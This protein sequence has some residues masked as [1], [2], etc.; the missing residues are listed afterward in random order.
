[1]NRVRTKKYLLLSFFFFLMPIITFLG[2][3]L[4][5]H[6]Y[7]RELPDSIPG[8]VVETPLFVITDF[9]MGYWSTYLYW[10]LAL[11]FLVL[12]ILFSSVNY[13]RASKLP[14]Q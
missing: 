5:E 14:P 1:M 8:V 7:P 11:F 6:F 3:M 2:R 12:Y 4:Y 9:F 13:L 10:P